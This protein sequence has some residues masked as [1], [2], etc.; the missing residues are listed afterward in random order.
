MSTIISQKRAIVIGYW[1]EV[2][3]CNNN[4]IGIDDIIQIIIKY[5]EDVIIIA[6]ITAANSVRGRKRTYAIYEIQVTT[7]P[8]VTMPWI[9]LKRFRDFYAL[10]DKLTDE[11]ESYDPEW[12]NQDFKLLPLPRK[13]KFTGTKPSAVIERQRK[14]EQCLKHIMKNKTLSK[15]DI[16]LDFLCVPDNVRQMIIID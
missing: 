3:F 11:I 1:F 12:K 5:A 13:K 15:M 8:Q 10:H 7:S 4:Y 6:T 16:V 2:L 14:L 9:V